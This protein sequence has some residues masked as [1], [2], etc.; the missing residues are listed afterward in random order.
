MNKNLALY[1]PSTSFPQGSDGGF[2]V[3]KIPLTQNK[4]A[5]VDSDMFDYLNQWKW[6]LQMNYASRRINDNIIY[7]HRL[8]TNVEDGLEVDHINGD[9]LDNRKSNLRKCTH[10]QNLRNKPVYKNSK[11]GYKGVWWKATKKR[12]I[13]C[14]VIGKVNNK[15]VRVQRSS[16]KLEDAIIKYNDLAKEYFGEYAWINKL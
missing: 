7:M 8:I 14:I 10:L 3:S 2:L 11:S 15:R 6:T 16:K 12:W 5:I 9:G 4:F 1:N 13:S